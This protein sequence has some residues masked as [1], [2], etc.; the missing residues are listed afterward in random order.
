MTLAPGMELVATAYEGGYAVGSFNA[1]GIEHAEAIV[2][3]AESERAPVIVQIS[4]NAVKYHGGELAPLGLACLSI[5]RAAR[6]PVGVHL[7]HAT[8][9]ELCAAALDLGFGS[10]M[11][12]ASTR[13]FE[14]NLRATADAAK[15]AHERGAGFEGELGVVAGKEG[16]SSQDRTDP[17]EAVRFVTGTRVDALAVAIGTAHQM[18]RQNAELD[19]PLLRRLREAVSVPLVLHGSSGVRDDDLREAPRWG[20]AKVNIATQ[21]NLAYTSAVRGYL[22]RDSAVTDPRRYLREARAAMV[23]V[24]RGRIRLLGSAD[25]ADEIRMSIPS[26][27]T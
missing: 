9:W 26:T 19:F 1:I 13:P 24:V 7:D 11:L 22:A 8:S 10:V 16:A 12:D 23:E 17:D 18:T 27:R 4:E 20:L 6:A 25:R 3:A 14:E 5:A 21:L 15:R 2:E